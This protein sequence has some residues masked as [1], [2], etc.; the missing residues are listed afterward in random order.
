MELECNAESIVPSGPNYTDVRYQTCSATGSEPGVLIVNGD[1]YLANNYGFYYSNVWRN[2]GI[3]MLFAV[4]FLII[5]SWLTEIIEWSDGATGAVEYRRNRRNRVQKVERRDVENKVD[6]SDPRAP[7]S[8]AK[9]MVLSDAT[10]I[11]ELQKTESAFTWRSLNYTIKTADGERML[12]NDVTGYCQPGELTA[13]VGSSG[14]G[15][16]T[17]KSK[18]W[19][20]VVLADTD[21]FNSIDDLNAARENWPCYRRPEGWRCPCRRHFP[22]S[23]RILPADGHPRWVQ[24]Y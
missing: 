9:N 17:R 14:A 23:H 8:S 13:L 15:K 16:S 21:D 1:A 24:H 6:D 19:C 10:A 7:P 3:L 5:S 2:F 22:P 4:A 11:G 12:L 18:S 20:E